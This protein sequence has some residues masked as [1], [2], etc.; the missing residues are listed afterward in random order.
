[1]KI[2][3]IY[4][5][6]VSLEQMIGYEIASIIWGQLFTDDIEVNIL[7]KTTDQLDAN[8]IGGAIPEFHEQHYALFLQY[9][10]ADITS[11]EDQLAFD[12]LQQGNTIDFLLDGDLVGGNTKLK[13]TTAL[14]KALGM[15]EAISLDRYVLDESENFVD[16][17]VMMNQN[18]AWD[19]N[20]L[21]NSEAAENTLDFLSVALHETG[22]ILGF[23]S[24]L[25][26]SLQEETLYSGRT[27]LSNFSPLD[28][29]RFSAESLAQDNPDGAVN[30]LSIGGVAWFSTDGGETLTAQMST[31]KEGDGYQ[32]SHWERRYD[33]LGI[34]DPTLW[35]QE[36][37]SIT[38]LDVLAFDLMGYDLSSGAKDVE[39]LF[40][41]Q[42]LE[43]ILAQAKV[44]L[45]DKMG[46][47][48]QYIEDNADVPVSSLELIGEIETAY[49]EAAATGTN[50][51]V[52]IPSFD[53]DSDS[54]LE[55]P[56]DKELKDFI[57]DLNQ[58]MR[59]SYHWWAQNNGGGNSSWQE[60]YEWWWQNNGGGN[61]SWQELY[62][63]W[64]QN[65]GGGNAAWQEVYQWW[66]QD[67][68]GGNS[69][70]Q[71]VFFASQD[72]GNLEN[73]EL[74]GE[75]NDTTVGVTYYKE[76]SGGHEDEIIGG[77]ISDDKILAGNGD[78]LIDGAEGNDTILGA[79]GN[80]TIFGFDGHDS[81][82]GG[83]GDDVIS[84]ESDND[85]L[86]GEAGADVL[87]GGD[88]DDYLDGGTGRDFLSG[89]T[90]HDVLLGGAGDDALE[91]EAG[92]DLLVGEAGKDIANGGSGDDYIFGDEYSE[93]LKQA[94]GSNLNPLTILFT[95]ADATTTETPV[96]DNTSINNIIEVVLGQDPI[97]IEA[98][99]MNLSGGYYPDN[100]YYN[101]TVIRTS[102]NNPSGVASSVFTGETGYYQ[103]VVRY[104]D[105]SDGN[106]SLSVKIADT[107]IDNWDL[108]QNSDDD[109]QY[110]TRTISEGMHIDANAAIEIQGQ[111]EN[112]EFAR[113]DYI[114]FVPVNTPT[115]DVVLG[116]DPII[117]EAENMT[118]SGGYYPDDQ[119]YDGTV[120]RT[121]SNNPS[122]VASSAFTG[123][124]GY[125]QVVVHY[126]DESDGNASLSVKIANTEIDSWV[127]DQNTSGSNQDH[128]RIISEGMYIDANAAI[129]IQGQ[130]E[131]SEYARVDYIEFIP[132]EAPID[133]SSA[134]TDTSNTDTSNTDTSSTLPAALELGENS[135]ILR[136]GNGNDGIDGGEGNDIIY[137]EDELNY[138]INITSPSIDGAFHYG[139]STYILSQNGT[140][141]EAQA[142]AQRYGG[143]L[144][145]IN[146]A[147][148]NQWLLDTFGV[149][150]DWLWTGF[151]DQD[152]EG[153]FEWI[154]GQ[155]TTYT[156]WAPGQPH[157][158]GG[159]QHYAILNWNN[160]GWDDNQG[161]WQWQGIIEID[162]SS[163]GGND[164]I[165]GGAGDDQ[166]Y[167]NS[168]NDLLYGDDTNT[169]QTPVSNTQGEIYNGSQYLVI[170]TATVWSK[171]QAYAESLGGNLV[172]INDAAEEKWLQDTFGTSEMF[173]IGLSDAETEG[174]WKW[175]SGEVS[176]WVKGAANDGIYTNWS[177]G[178]PDDYNGF[179]DY[180]VMNY[181][182]SG[183]TN[184]LW[185]DHNSD[186]QYRGIIE[187]KLP[188]T[189]NNDNLM[190]NGGHD[191]IN[192]GAGDDIINGTDGI[193]AGY[194][195]RD[196]LNGGD[197]ADTFVLGD[198]TQAY[199]ANGG[200]QD[201]AV[202][203]DFKYG[204][205]NLQLHGAAV[206]YQQVQQG[207]DVHLTRNG[208]LVAILENNSTLTINIGGFE[209]V[210]TI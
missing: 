107:E 194:L 142:E 204:L 184:N 50:A 53:S 162:W 185:D 112:W 11:E 141:Q 106:A 174:T 44:Q 52:N 115:N 206:D 153:Q 182:M 120:I 59:H 102:S 191:T 78:D 89:N 12:A 55:S 205:D 31:G 119:Y 203:Q 152:Q 37:A 103:V 92:K 69:W 45:A 163:V 130:A 132:V 28:L 170:E 128:S 198:K 133:N 129:E 183:T 172:T 87:M 175:A 72:E 21:R 171:A 41:S 101:G 36:R 126:I 139:H 104:I 75:S 63:W 25:D 61:S 62:E 74:P 1:M 190:G 70:W 10:E 157:D 85:V 71:E 181:T 23:T 169:V 140:W 167:G 116:Q 83:V 93:S 207:N 6:D 168:G 117:I 58:M 151:T 49:L 65:N 30:D 188:T 114:E 54:G 208:D 34:M 22:H 121:S 4:A 123:E 68:G 197:G 100:Q 131:S 29:F 111:A 40:E 166:I 67:N 148:E 64:M 179:Q 43:V 27:E 99:N 187:I 57:K 144:V 202:I 145:T 127:L 60:L 138:L 91:G 108:D 156:N 195:E 98:E 146:D 209:Y 35:Y 32:A 14:A 77:D 189:N 113:V 95:P 200:A 42:N 196:V 73:V 136:G 176:D 193:V 124:T 109:N 81:I 24:S 38:D 9:Y 79:E 2:N 143:N 48:V 122:G 46:F 80:D 96:V 186:A 90:G 161:T 150:N 178:Q 76:I 97:I 164:T 155:K 147:A 39:Q 210:S 17:T 125:Y 118:L 199:Y 192:G 15:N 201:Y 86:F 105:E 149:N 20:Y 134:P 26:F 177:P 13:L 47:S 3:F 8:V 51:T 154:S 165:Y 7:A 94:F 158:D 66:M 16:G 19:F 84:G 173:W 88:H 137:G 110:Y 18:F 56:E 82:M 159:N 5:P 180:A 160:Q 135:D 33:P